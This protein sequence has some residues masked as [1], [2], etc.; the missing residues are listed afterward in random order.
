MMKQLTIAYEKGDL[1]ALLRLELECLHKE[2]DNLEKLSDDKLKI[3]NQA[4]KEQ[5]EELELE[6]DLFVQHPRYYPLQKYVKFFGIE[7]IDLEEEKQNLE[8]DI[9]YMTKDLEVLEG[10][11]PLKKLK[12]IIKETKRNLKNKQT[13]SFDFEDLFR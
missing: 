4:L 10:D 13:F 9:N 11:K 5:I 12:E 1:H 6:I 2:E 7:N 8:Y 3:Y